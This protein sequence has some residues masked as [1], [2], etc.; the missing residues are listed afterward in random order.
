M[1]GAAGTATFVA[2]A[3]MTTSLVTADALVPPSDENVIL[4]YRAAMY[5]AAAVGVVL[6]AMSARLKRNREKTQ[7]R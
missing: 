3:T 1:A 5:A 6:I 4:G 2:V 7:L